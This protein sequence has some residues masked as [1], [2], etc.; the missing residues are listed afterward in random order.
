MSKMSKPIPVGNYLVFFLDQIGVSDSLGQWKDYQGL[1]NQDPDWSKAFQ[2]S[3]IDIAQIR[4]DFDGFRSGANQDTS[5]NPEIKRMEKEHPEL[6]VDT[7]ATRDRNISGQSFSDTNIWF[8]PT[9]DVKGRLY[10]RQMLS[11][12]IGACAVMIQT[13]HRGQ[14]CRGSIALGVG[15]EALQFFGEQRDE[16]FGPVLERAHYL[17]TQVADYPRV[18]VHNRLVEFL[19]GRHWDLSNYKSGTVEYA[20]KQFEN[21]YIENI[22]DLI[23][24]DED[25]VLILDYAGNACAKTLR[26][27]FAKE[28]I[29]RSGYFQSIIEAVISERKRFMGD[30]KK[31]RIADKY[32]KLHHYLDKNKAYWLSVESSKGDTE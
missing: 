28:G 11:M 20:T 31:P 13:L 9:S 15:T 22:L 19:G 23:R 7:S 24:P 32:F 4:S 12:V 2:K 10:C 16:I 29:D 30:E 17:E 5:A 27:W 1:V 25:G 18:V 8:V 21:S 14:Y 6:F 3:I 26:G